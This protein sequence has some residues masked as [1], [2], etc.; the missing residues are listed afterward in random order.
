MVKHTQTIRRQ[1]LLPT[2]WLSVSD[3]FVV[4]APKGLSFS[5]C[6]ANFLTV[7][8]IFYLHE[9]ENKHKKKENKVC[10]VY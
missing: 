6:Q 2:N 4:L 9:Y 5:E 3:H 7:S 10:I 8:K 1:Q